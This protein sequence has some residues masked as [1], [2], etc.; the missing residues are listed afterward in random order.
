ML[1]DTSGGTILNFKQSIVLGVA[2]LSAAFW[3]AAP[4]SAQS[5]FDGTWKINMSTAKFST[6]PIVFYVAQGWY[7]CD[8]CTPVVAVKADGTDQPVTGQAYDT[9]NVKQVSDDTLALTTMKNGKVTNEQTRTVSKDGKTL[10]VKIKVHHA[11]SDTIDD[12][13]ATAKLVGPKPSGVDASSGNWQIIK[14]TEGKP[15]TM[16]IKVNGD[17]VN[18]SEPTGMNYTAKLDGTS[19]PV[20][21]SF[22]VDSVSVKKVDANTLETTGSRD[23][24]TV[25]VSKWTVKGKTLSD[26]TTSKPSERTSTFTWTKQ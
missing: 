18:V 6:K 19:A 7:H 11:D 14:E 22:S 24:Q 13:E 1:K 3:A 16:T 15:E 26:E 5:P 20:K 2:A 9:L 25:Y 23:G 8:S 17:E 12:I 21:G 10:T 4:V